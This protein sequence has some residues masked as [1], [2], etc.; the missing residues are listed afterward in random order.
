MSSEKIRCG[1]CKFFDWLPH[2]DDSADGQCH[3][4]PPTR[5]A[6]K[7][8]D[9]FPFVCVGDWCGEYETKE[10]PLDDVIV[11]RLPIRVA[12][13]LQSFNV[14]TYSKL[15]K[16]SEDEILACKGSGEHVLRCI[17]DLLKSKGWY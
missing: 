13:V 8:F 1:H 6:G 5:N 4:H 15:A 7:K 14:K 10:A 11:K 12:R 17:K 3:R 2:D 9:L 16:L